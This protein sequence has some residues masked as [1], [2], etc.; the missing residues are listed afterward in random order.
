MNFLRNL[1]AGEADGEQANGEQADESVDRA[2]FSVDELR[3]ARLARL[4]DPAPGPS[5]HPDVAK[6]PWKD[7]RLT[8]DDTVMEDV[9]Q[10]KTKVIRNPADVALEFVFQMSIFKSSGLV[11]LLEMENEFVAEGKTSAGISV[12][13]LEEALYSR[14][15]MS[16]LDVPETLSHPSPLDYLLVSL[17]RIQQYGKRDILGDVIEAL[18]TAQIFVVSYSTTCL[19]EPDMFPSARGSTPREVLI[20]MLNG[21]SRLFS[22]SSGTD[23]FR[24]FMNLLADECVKQESVD[25]ILKPIFLKL[26]TDVRTSQS[27]FMQNTVLAVLALS[28]PK[29]FASWIAKFIAD[30]ERTMG[31]WESPKAIQVQNS[32]QN[33][34]PG[35]DSSHPMYN[36]MMQM[37]QNRTENVSRGR[38]F[39]LESSM[40]T[41][42]S[43]STVSD[44]VIQDYYSNILEKG[45]VE[46]RGIQKSIQGMF[47]NYT[48]SLTNLLLFLCKASPD[49][50]VQVLDWVARGLQLNAARSQSQ[51]NKQEVSDDGLALNLAVV[52]LQLCKPIVKDSVNKMGLIH[53]AFVCNPDAPPTSIGFPED[54]S[55]LGTGVGFQKDV[56]NAVHPN[57][58]DADFNFV[59]RCF[60]YALRAFHLGPVSVAQR[61]NSYERHLSH[62]QRQFP[63][64]VAPR[65]LPSNER[66]QFASILGKLFA[67]EAGAFEP[68]M[69][70][71]GMALY[72]LYCEWL[73]AQ[74]QPGDLDDVPVPLPQPPNKVIA[75]SP[76]HIVEDV[77]VYLK[78]VA[79]HGVDA[80]DT[81]P[82]ESLSVVLTT[83]VILMASPSYVYSPHLRAMFAETIFSVFLPDSEK[84]NERKTNGSAVS[85]SLRGNL[86]GLSPLVCRHLAPGLLE[87]YGDVESTGHYEAIGH[88]Q[89]IALVLKFIWNIPSHRSAFHSFASSTP[90][91]FINFANGILNQTN[92]G[93]AESLSRLREIRT[94]QMDRVGTAWGLLSEESQQ[95]RTQGY[96]ENEQYVS[97]ALLLANE[98]LSMIRYLSGDNVFVAAFLK[99]E[100]VMRLANMLCSVLAN[101]AGPQGVLLKIDNPEK[102]NFFPKDLLV[103]VYETIGSFV[104]SDKTEVFIP[105]IAAS[106]F[107]F[108]GYFQQSEL[109]SGSIWLY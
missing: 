5:S 42:F 28:K 98:V 90:E 10:K 59:T 105:A 102:Y 99:P 95:Q 17:D 92:D 6:Q 23:T 74:S 57:G 49:S 55:R 65:A 3:A 12:D 54:I 101:L 68:S 36:L 53:A 70:Q 30:E 56:L 87:L 38:R 45:I 77:A 16:V 100:L 78:E 29:P 1:V 26:V 69:V 67:S 25:T 60:F 18:E 35:V 44:A 80:L 43:P 82:S 39:E 47:S 32:S 24:L 46:I 106:P 79:Y 58:T 20:Q 37:V 4:A 83:F 7:E 2:P 64:A 50:K 19:V 31:G 88:R 85:Q 27:G 75:S 89:H 51:P 15:T 73:I 109:P 103:K 97:S 8:D 93:V 48:S 33:L 96:E 11:H 62:L 40:A 34:P 72:A 107:F 52:M 71:E 84:S 66:S 63:A 94:Y 13:N 41:L 81:C 61:V 86:L 14:L 22:S 9:V 76:Q 21:S 108:S 91:K 104:V